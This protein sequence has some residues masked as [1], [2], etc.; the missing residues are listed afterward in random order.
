MTLLP[1]TPALTEENKPAGGIVAL[2]GG[3]GGAKLALGLYRQLQ[4]QKQANR[5]SV[6]VNTGDD[7]EYL[8]LDISPDLDTV[9]YTLAG[10]ANPQTGW[11]IEGDT[12]QALEMLG[13]YGHDNWF[14][15]GDRDLATHLIRTERLYRGDSLTRITEDF[16]RSL[17]IEC[18]VLPMCNEQV[19]TLVTTEEAGVLPFQEYFVRRHAQDTVTNLQYKGIE[20]ATLSEE[21]REVL[22]DPAL[23]V[24]CPS[25]PYLSLAPI[26]AVPGMRELIRHTTAPVVVISPIVGGAALKGPAAALM[27]SFGGENEASALGI[28]R[29][30]AGFAGRFVL[31]QQD[32]AQQAQIEELA[33]KVMVTDTVMTDEAAKIRLA[34]EIL[35]GFG[36]R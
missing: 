12:G 36:V 7:M 22:T 2:A 15:L 28:A 6:I 16:R 17:G 20:A 29:L 3:V 14:W 24:L 8:G 31:D 11:G 21:V 10:L 18:R 5:L 13:R 26:L 27:R 19:R 35:E 1:Q 23:I 25:N 33:F 30:Y 32:V 34:R 9:M 4:S